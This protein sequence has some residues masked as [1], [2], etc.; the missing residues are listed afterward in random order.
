M[1]YYDEEPKIYYVCQNCGEHLC[2]VDFLDPRLRSKE[3]H[4]MY[5]I[6]C[7]KELLSNEENVKKMLNGLEETAKELLCEYYPKNEEYKHM[8]EEEAFNALYKIM[9][10]G[11][12]NEDY[13]HGNLTDDQKALNDI[14]ELFVTEMEGD[15]LLSDDYPEE[16]EEAMDV[17]GFLVDEAYER[18]L[19]DKYMR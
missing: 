16:Y 8:G 9:L 17:E 1:R 6:D 13:Y 18:Y 15:N 5:C 4:A 10:D 12:R 14:L 2:E 7:V 11:A 3:T 19:D